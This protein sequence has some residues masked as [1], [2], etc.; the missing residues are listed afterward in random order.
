MPDDTPRF[1]EVAPRVWVAHYDWMHVNIT[2]IGGSD[3]LLMVDTHGSAA[4]ARIVAD[5]VR[6]LLERQRELGTPHN[7]EWVH[8]TTPSLLAAAQEATTGMP[9]VELGQYPLLVLPA[10][11]DVPDAPDVRILDADDP[12]L[13]ASNDVVHAAFGGSDEIVESF[14]RC[15]AEQRG[16][17]RAAVSRTRK[18]R[19][20]ARTAIADDRRQCERGGRLAG[21]LTAAADRPLAAIQ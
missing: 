6:R 3:G 19:H 12:D 16:G 10:E 14:A 21:E 8:Q 9:G 17:S 11:V 18:Q 20:R 15:S 7:L 4:E 5:D 13:G 1:T 2:L